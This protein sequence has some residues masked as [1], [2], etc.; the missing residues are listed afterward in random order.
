MA[1]ETDNIEKTV[2][3]IKNKNVKVEPIRTDEYTGKKFTFFFDPDRLPLEIYENNK[4][5]TNI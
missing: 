4:L 5:A 3:K 2:E 1:L